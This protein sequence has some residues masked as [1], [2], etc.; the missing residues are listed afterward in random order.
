MRLRIPFYR[1]L[2]KISKQRYVENKRSRGA[3]IGK[4][5]RVFGTI[6]NVNPHL[7]SIG[8]FSVIGTRSHII[9]HGPTKAGEVKIG[10]CVYIGYG[11]LVLP[12]VTIGDYALIGAGSVVTKNVS[13][14]M[15]VAGVPAKELGHRAR[16]SIIEQL[17]A[18][19]EGRAC[20]AEI[21][22]GDVFE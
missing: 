5:V 1:R 10:K 18:I 16:S 7:V 3:I 8:D 11:A 19:K 21:V 14:R 2:M 4:H 15:V 20:G 9:A 17:A 12:G 13:P 6:D 22:T